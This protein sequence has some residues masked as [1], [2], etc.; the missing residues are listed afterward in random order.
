MKRT[1][2]LL[3]LFVFAA[4]A[5]VPAHCPRSA[6]RLLEA[7]VGD[8]GYDR[9]GMHTFGCKFSPNRQ[10]VLC[11]VSAYKGDGAASDTY[12]VVLAKTCDELVRLQLIGEE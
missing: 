5:A 3:P 6:S 12:R 7:A 9:D 1:L 8:L 2:A 4:E 10:V 11:D